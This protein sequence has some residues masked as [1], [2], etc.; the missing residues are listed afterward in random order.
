M[1]GGGGGKRG[2][3]GGEI[4]LKCILTLCVVGT[5][6]VSYFDKLRKDFCE[7]AGEV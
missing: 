6:H 5:L 3:G 1:G 2:S 7:T 4:I